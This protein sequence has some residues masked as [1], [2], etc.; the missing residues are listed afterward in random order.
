MADNPLSGGSTLWLTPAGHFEVI[1]AEQM[2]GAR[3]AGYTPATP[4]QVG[5]WLKEQSFQTT[6]QQLATFGEHAASALTFGLSTPLEI[7]AGIPAEDIE[8]RTKLNPMAGAAGTIAGI[9]APLAL[10]PLGAMTAPGAISRVGSAVRA[11]AEALPKAETAIGRIA[12]RALA[13]GAGSAVEGAAYAG[14]MVVSE[15]ALG[16]PRLTA[17]AMASQ[18][19]TGALLGLGVGAGTSAVWN[20]GKEALEGFSASSLGQK[21][22]DWLL[23]EQ[24]QLS[25]KS[26]KAELGAPGVTEATSGQ[27]NRVMH[28]A[29]QY[30]IIGGWTT[31]KRALENSTGFIQTNMATQDAI[32]NQ[33]DK[34]LKPNELADVH[35]LVSKARFSSG[36]A[37]PRGDLRSQFDGKLSDLEN[38]FSTLDSK[39]N[40]SQLLG[41]EREAF[42]D[43]DNAAHAAGHWDGLAQAYHDLRLQVQDTMTDMAKG[44]S[45]VSP[46]LLT[47][48]KEIAHRVDVGRAA[49]ALAE[50]GLH[51]MEIAAGEGSGHLGAHVLMGEAYQI[52]KGALTGTLNPVR[53]AKGFLL[54]FGSNAGFKYAEPMLAGMGA[55]A[56]GMGVEA[57]GGIPPIA[58]DVAQSLA[59]QAAGAGG[60]TYQP[61][62]GEV[63]GT[64]FMVSDPAYEFAMRTGAPLTKQVVSNYASKYGKVFSQDPNAYL[65][66][67]QDANKWYL[68]ISNLMKDRAEA[69]IAGAARHQRAIYD[70]AAHESIS[71]PDTMA[72]RYTQV[73]NTIPV[74][75]LSADNPFT[76]FGAMLAGQVGADIAP[77]PRGYAIGGEVG[78]PF[79]EK[80]AKGMDSEAITELT[81]KTGAMTQASRLLHN[82]P[83]DNPSSIMDSPEKVAILAHFERSQQEVKQ[84]VLKG[85]KAVVNGV[86]GSVDSDSHLSGVQHTDESKA[87]KRFQGRAVKLQALAQDSNA[88]NAVTNEQSW[89]WAEHAPATAQA[90][91]QFTQGVV[92]YLTSKLPISYSQGPLDE[93]I[94]PSAMD[95]AQFNRVW[96]AVDDPILLLKQAAKGTVT[97]EAVDAVRNVYPALFDQMQTAII[98]AI[99]DRKKPV[100]YLQRLAISDIMGEPMDGT[101]RFTSIMANQGVYS[102]TAAQ[103]PQAPASTQNSNKPQKITLP[104]RTQ[105]DMQQ[106]AARSEKEP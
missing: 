7:A 88:M 76:A 40:Y 22:R 105:T 96:A 79:Q 51:N 14:S 9:A 60:F 71:I 18:V 55:R 84:Q 16:N 27:T 11:A 36:S 52:A 59:S 49:K 73:G 3:D 15:S 34:T 1:P 42:Q 66:A 17:E 38:R 25:A 70:L 100:P 8:A 4:Q 82:P 78:Q 102:S 23:Q 61:T 104:K 90:L 12:A 29:N 72:A 56:A 106:S 67:W 33:I 87:L 77:A 37:L 74:L 93:P 20:A 43:V 44:A 46:G 94:D 103:A 68:D 6:G 57:L 5:D 89:D 97:P 19:A 31:P 86:G 39:A 64:G 54:G 26:L 63:P 32:A 80:L 21:A 30:G 24:A 95:I 75:E 83:P 45:E 10:G 69:L 92:Q 65:G 50:N 99:A 91:Q 41:I 2:L 101:M 85:A 48:A 98:G 28:E 13:T 53:L 62:S 58:G 47:S 81:N 35:D